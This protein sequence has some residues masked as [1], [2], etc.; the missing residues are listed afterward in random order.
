MDT[1]VEAFERAYP[2]RVRRY[3]IRRGSGGAGLYGGGDGI[4]RE[5]EALEP[6]TIS[7]I[8]ERRVSRPWGLAGGE[9]GIVGKNW[10]LRGGDESRAER[11]LD[12]C[13]IELQTGDVLRL[14]TPGGGGWG[15]AHDRTS[16]VR[17]GGRTMIRVTVMCDRPLSAAISRSD[18]RVQQEASGRRVSHQP[19]DEVDLPDEMDLPSRCCRDQGGRCASCWELSQPS[20]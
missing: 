3:T 10:L 9:P 8:T 19:R 17:P 20:L 12:K 5:L 11:V 4:V 14:L 13:T 15:D 2:M 16:E 7:L 6:C 18:A 1:P